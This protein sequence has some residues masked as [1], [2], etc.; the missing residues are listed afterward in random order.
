MGICPCAAPE[1]HCSVLWRDFI[2]FVSKEKTNKQTKIKQTSKWEQQKG[3]MRSC[4]LFWLQIL[5]SFAD[6]SLLSNPKPSC[7]PRS[8]TTPRSDTTSLGQGFQP[9]PCC[10]T[11]PCYKV[12]KKSLQ[13]QKISPLLPPHFLAAAETGN[14]YISWARLFSRECQPVCGEQR[15]HTRAGLR[16]L[17][18]L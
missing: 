7:E 11:F 4:L 16:R 10:K 2:L 9:A 18:G 15:L 14:S 17:R 5:G 8:N 3:F 13:I 6:I 12:R 1:R